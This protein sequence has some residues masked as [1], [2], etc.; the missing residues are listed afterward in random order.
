MLSVQGEIKLLECD[1]LILESVADFMRDFDE[2][3]KKPEIYAAGLDV[4]IMIATANE[5]VCRV[6]THCEWARYFM[7]RHP[8]VAF[9]RGYNKN[10]RM[11]R[12]T[13]IMEGGSECDFRWYSVKQAENIPE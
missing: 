7:E 12:K 13:T 8:S 9:G 5:H 2:Q 4:E 11:Q 3:L 10:I 1:P 6:V